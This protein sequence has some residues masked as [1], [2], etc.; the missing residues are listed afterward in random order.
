MAQSPQGRSRS[1][2]FATASLIRSC[3]KDCV[4]VFIVL[5]SLSHEDFRTLRL[6]LPTSLVPRHAHLQPLIGITT[7]Y[8]RG[9]QPIP[10]ASEYDAP[11]KIETY[12][13]N[14]AMRTDPRTDL[15]AAS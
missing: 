11:L 1:P 8:F 4:R 7:S 15:R 6:P 3:I 2:I 9:N 10:F 14:L 13:L 5:S 12:Y